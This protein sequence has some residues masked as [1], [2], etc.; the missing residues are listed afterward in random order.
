MCQRKFGDGDTAKSAFH[1]NRKWELD[2]FYTVKRPISRVDRVHNYISLAASALLLLCIGCGSNSGYEFIGPE[3]SIE[4]TRYIRNIEP[5]YAERVE[6]TNRLRRSIIGWYQQEHSPDWDFQRAEFD[7]LSGL[8]SGLREK[9]S[10]IDPGK[11]DLQGPH[12]NYLDAWSQ[13]LDGV[14]IILTIINTEGE[15]GSIIDATKLIDQGIKGLES[16]PSSLE[17]DAIYRG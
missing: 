13:C 6:V 2:M 5:I 12:S 8:M 3:D 16:F 4:K 14:S 7:T 11:D 10:E 17:R 1:L 15:Q 9:A